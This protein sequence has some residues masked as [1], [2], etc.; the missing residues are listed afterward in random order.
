MP[1]VRADQ[2]AQKNPTKQNID[3]P[4]VAPDIIQMGNVV[5]PVVLVAL[6]AED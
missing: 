2:P 3:Q 4:V 5:A 1:E 6:E